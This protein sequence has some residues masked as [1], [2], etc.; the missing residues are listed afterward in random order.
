[1]AHL[2]ATALIY[3]VG[4]LC[5][6]VMTLYSLWRIS[7]RLPEGNAWAVIAWTAFGLLALVG[8]VSHFGTAQQ[9]WREWQQGRIRTSS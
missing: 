7:V 3:G 9:H 4:S 6:A 2:V 1:M 8:M 5:G